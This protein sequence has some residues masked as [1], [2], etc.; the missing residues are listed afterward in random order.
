MATCIGDR[1]TNV[2]TQIFL[3]SIKGQLENWAEA[4]EDGRK[5]YEERKDHFLRYIQHP[6][7]LTELSVDPL[8]DDP[9]VCRCPYLSDAHIVYLYLPALVPVEYCSSG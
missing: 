7:A 8:A 9:D 3:L 2:Y 4:L 6:E 1:L 5:D